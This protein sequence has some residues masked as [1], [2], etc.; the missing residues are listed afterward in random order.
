MFLLKETKSYT[1]WKCIMCNNI[2]KFLKDQ[3][4]IIWSV[5]VACIMYVCLF[6]PFLT[7]STLYFVFKSAL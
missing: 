6:Y 2:K 7:L 4:F 1:L 3:T 5:N